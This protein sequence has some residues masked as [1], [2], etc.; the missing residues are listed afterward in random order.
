MTRFHTICLALLS[1]AA[2]LLAPDAR[3]AQPAEEEWPL[4]G[5]FKK[6]VSE[7]MKPERGDDAVQKL[8][9]ERYNTALALVEAR[10]KQFVAG[11][12]TASAF[13]DG[14]D[15]V[16]RARMGLTDKPADLIPLLELRL[17]LAREV[18]KAAE[19]NFEAGRSDAD[20]PPAAK[21]A[22][23]NAEIDLLRMKKRASTE[24]Q[25]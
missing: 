3:T 4:L 20:A 9:K 10:L 2:L 15:Q 7:P 1:V 14:L 24:K 16:L 12:G 11:R 5:K 19:A 6:L 23:I 22:R 13:E 8:M 21:I 18:E 17:D 25:P